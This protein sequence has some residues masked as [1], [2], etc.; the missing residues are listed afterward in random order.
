[1]RKE[2]GRRKWEMTRCKKT[3]RKAR[4]SDRKT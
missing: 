1:M 2:I 4:G 3:E